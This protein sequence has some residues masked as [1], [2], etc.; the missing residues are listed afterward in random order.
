MRLKSLKAEK[1]KKKKR[2][3]DNH[4]QMSSIETHTAGETFSFLTITRSWLCSLY[5]SLKILRSQDTFSFTSQTIINPSFIYESSKSRDRKKSL[6]TICLWTQNQITA[7]FHKLNLVM[8]GNKTSGIIWSISF[9]F[10][11]VWR[12]QKVE[13]KEKLGTQT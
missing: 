7:L 4:M 2:F 8:T 10:V 12:G 1:S 11:H 6:L 13:Y 9:W 3:S 5:N